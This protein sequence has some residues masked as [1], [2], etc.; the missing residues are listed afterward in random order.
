[1]PK[2]ST[3]KNTPTLRQQLRTE[4]DVT[5]S[6]L[7]VDMIAAADKVAGESGVDAHDLMRIAAGGASTKTLREKLIGDL[8]NQVERELLKIFTDRQAAKHLGESSA[9]A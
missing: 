9:E 5:L 8:A 7:M 4:A 1:M 2:P 3:K 6:G